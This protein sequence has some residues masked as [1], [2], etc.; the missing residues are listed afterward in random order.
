MLAAMIRATG[1]KVRMGGNMGI[2]LLPFVER[3]Q[4]DEMIVL[5]VSSVQL[6]D[7]AQMQWA[8]ELS[9][10]TNITPNH[11]DHYGNFERYARA[12]KNILTY[13]SES[14][15]CVLNAANETLR[16]WAAE[17]VPANLLLFDPHK[18]DGPLV[19]GVNLRGERLVWNYNGRQQLICSIDNIAVPGRHNVSNAMAAAAAALWLDVPV[20]AVRKALAEFKTLEHRLERCG[21]FG[22]ISFYNDSDATTP[23]STIAGLKSFPGPV[24]LIAGGKNKNLDMRKLGRAIATNARVLITLGQAGP[25]IQEATRSARPSNACRQPIAHEADSLQE[26]VEVAFDLSRPGY[27]VLF[28]PACA[29]F[30][31]FENFA[32]RGRCFK[33]VVRQIGVKRRHEAS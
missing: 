16:G 14:H 17:G 13:Q 15:G 29:S 21:T 9:L 8:P 11:L 24:T 7:A 10:I 22:G 28:S 3:T 4:P 27:T 1:R 30:D 6:E 32:Q 19:Q 12:K 26:A 25:Q 18:E 5:E 33:D 23:E 20:T 31:M 2:S